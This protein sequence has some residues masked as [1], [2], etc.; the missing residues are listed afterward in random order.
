MRKKRITMVF[1]ET[2]LCGMVLTAVA[3]AGN[4]ASMLAESKYIKNRTSL[5]GTYTS[6]WVAEN[7]QYSA[8]ISGT[9]R[10]E[11]KAE[12]VTISVKSNIQAKAKTENYWSNG[13]YSNKKYEYGKASKQVV[14]TITYGSGG[15]ASM[16]VKE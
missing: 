4:R 10:L 1:F 6:T 15:S 12:K 8:T 7:F 3:L 11:D 2:L 16:T 5:T 14:V 13:F 9:D